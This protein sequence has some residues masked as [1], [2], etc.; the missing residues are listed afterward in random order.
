MDKNNILISALNIENISQKELS[1]KSSVDLIKRD[2]FDKLISKL[3]VSFNEKEI[4]KIFSI[5]EDRY[6]SEKEIL[7]LSYEEVKKLKELIMEEDENGNVYDASL[8]RSS[9]KVSSF[10]ATSLISDN[11]DFNKAIFEKL[12]TL[13]DEKETVLFMAAITGS[14]A[15]QSVVAWDEKIDD[16][17]KSFGFKKIKENNIEEYLKDK[18]KYFK[19]ILDDGV[20]TLA[21]KTYEKVLSWY[22]DILEN[23]SSI[24]KEREYKIA[25]II[26]NNKPNPLEIL[27]L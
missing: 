5:V 2:D 11:E 7:S 8:I 14:F 26:R 17:G 24:K 22:E 18:I 13:K 10:M 4:N 19:D 20:S 21:S 15:I 3:E 6:I 1:D 16:E 27:S 12:K 9:Y 23:Y 25:Q